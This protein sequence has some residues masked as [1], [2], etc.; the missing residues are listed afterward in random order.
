MA[1]SPASP[2]P[3][4]TPCVG[5]CIV[6]GQSGLCLGCLRTLAEIAGWSGFDD[7][8]RAAIM[9]ALPARVHRLSPQKRAMRNR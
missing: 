6:D 7:A 9:T 1:A 2:A 8:D 5:V 3:I 4:V